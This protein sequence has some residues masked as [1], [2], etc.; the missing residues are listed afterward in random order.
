[1]K[2]PS[3]WCQKQKN[4]SQKNKIQADMN[5]KILN[6]ILANRIQH[7]K[8]IIYHDQVG[9]IPGMQEFFNICK[10]IDAIP[11]INKLKDKKLCGNFN[12]H[13]KIF[14]QVSASIYDENSIKH[15]HRRI[16][17]NY[18]NVIKAICDKSTT[19]IILKWWKTESIPFKIRDK[20][21]VPTFA[22][23]IQHSFGSPIYGNQRRKINKWNPDWKRSKTLFADDMILYIENPTDTIRK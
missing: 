16:E 22:T 13:S 8:K 15:G 1:M 12:R 5:V 4:T 17:G 9:F 14:W 10:S 11:H 19:D 2:Q 23:A 18:F 3:P 21:R 20:A 6:K 7:I